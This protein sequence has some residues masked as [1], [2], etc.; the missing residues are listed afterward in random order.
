MKLYAVSRSPFAARV[1]A[2]IALKGLD[3]EV[4]PP[5][6][7]GLKSPVFLALNPMGKL[8]T[9][10]LDDGTPLPESEV[11]VEY[12]DHAFPAVPLNPAEPVARAQSRLLARVAEL[13]VMGPLFGLFAHLGAA[14]DKQEVERLFGQMEIRPRLSRASLGRGSLCAGRCRVSR[15][16]RA[17][18]LSFL[19]G[20]N[21]A[22]VRPAK[23]ARG[24]SKAHAL[25]RDLAHP[26]SLP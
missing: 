6:E 9:L 24:F 23:F 18:T 17:C 4:V 2:A 11:I 3:I 12:L 19:G 15:G 22:Y 14:E 7:E 10:V 8:P 5:P 26:A 21:S 25:W 13:Y 20:R 16:L 1:Q